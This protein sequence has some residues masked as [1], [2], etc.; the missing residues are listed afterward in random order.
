VHLV[1]FYYTKIKEFLS[2]CS[3]DKRFTQLN[4]SERQRV[5]HCA[6][7]YHIFRGRSIQASWGLKIIQLLGPSWKKKNT[8]N[9]EYKITYENEY[10]FRMRKEIIENHKL[11]K[12]TNTTSSTKSRKITIFLSSKCLTHTHI[13]NTFS[14]IFW[15]HTLW[16]PLHRTTIL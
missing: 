4:E 15:L 7:Y 5:L 6:R 3:E 10:L 12:L 1:G 9:Y 16:S 14:H 13:Y 8:Q 2:N 11:K